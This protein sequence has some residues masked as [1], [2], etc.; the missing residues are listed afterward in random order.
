MLPDCGHKDQVVGHMGSS[1]QKGDD[2]GEVV[3]ATQLG[4]GETGLSSPGSWGSPRPACDLI[5]A[6]VWF[7]KRFPILRLPHWR[8]LTECKGSHD[9]G[10]NSIFPVNSALHWEAACKKEDVGL[11]WSSVTSAAATCG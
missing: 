2:Q 1:A 11:P 5:N 9:G 6:R 10:A 3:G 8:S 7:G 4:I